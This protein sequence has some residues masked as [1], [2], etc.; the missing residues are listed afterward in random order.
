MKKKLLSLCLILTMALSLFSGV[1]TAGAP[2]LPDDVFVPSPALKISGNTAFEPL[3]ELEIAQMLADAPLT[4][5]EALFA[6]EPSLA[7]P[8]TPGKL[9]EEALKAATDRLNLLRRLAGLPGVEQDPFRNEMAQ[10]GAVLLANTEFSHTPAK[11]EGMSQAF[12][13]KAYVATNSSN[14]AGGVTLTKAIDLFMDDSDLMNLQVLGH[15]RWQLNPLMG[16]VGFGYVYDD[17]A[18]NTEA[19]SDYEN[20]LF[21]YR[22]YA[23]E[24]VMDFSAEAFDYD[25]IGWP[26]SGNF[27]N[28][29]FN[30][31][32]A[33]SVSLNP[34]KYRTPVKEEVTVTL[35]AP[36]GTAHTFAGTE[37]YSVE[38]AKYFNVDNNGY[39][40]G[41]CII[42]RPEQQALYE[43]TYRVEI[44]GLKDKDGEAVTLCYEVDFFDAADYTTGTD[45]VCTIKRF[46]DIKHT[47]WYHDAVRYA[48][49][50]GLM[51]GTGTT[52][53]E[54]YANLTRA[55]IVQVLYNREGKP[56][57][58]EGPFTDVKNTKWYADAIAWSAENE[59]VKGFEDNTFRPEAPITRQQMATILYRYAEYKGY[60][61]TPRGDLTK[62]PDGDKTADWAKDA[63]EWALAVGLMQGDDKGYFDP[64][65]TA[66][67]AQVATVL[68]NYCE[69]IAK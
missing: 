65:G 26:A 54:P 64:E 60:D 11:P 46:A 15:R 55:M 43:G 34:E 24:Y 42:F 66:T 32:S 53:F 37:P 12:Y 35:T 17:P 2:T 7:D 63:V 21:N 8:H 33:W 1:A 58:E 14:L 68:M 30:T 48:V 36:D 20:P 45:H 59:I 23:T 22:H 57:A 16:T 44:T 29:L 39:G 41:S 47:A 62:F 31:T 67:R 4:L 9:T 56:A 52:K 49:D 25:F 10:Y 19:E 13:D 69:K 28:E 18:D 51:N 27:P 3:T 5:P 40:V 50:N 61:I 6:E 38:D